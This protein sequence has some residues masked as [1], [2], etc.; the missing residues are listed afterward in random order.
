ML[1]EWDQ[2]THIFSELSLIE[3]ADIK[4]AFRFFCHAFKVVPDIVRESPS[5]GFMT[6]GE[7]DRFELWFLGRLWPLLKDR[8]F[9][10]E[11]RDL[12]SQVL[13]FLI[14]ALKV[15]STQGES[16]MDFYC[17]I[18]IAFVGMTLTAIGKC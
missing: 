1:S 11:L 17:G 12:F 8:S 5:A 6:N 16:E 9:P 7:P 18:C 3:I 14:D 4:S 10:E 15:T 2:K 13:I